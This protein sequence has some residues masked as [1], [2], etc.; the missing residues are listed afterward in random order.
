[1]IGLL[2]GLVAAYLVGS[3][4]SG[5]WVG[6]LTSGVDVRTM[7]SRRTGATNVQRSLG[8]G[9]GIV[10]LLIDFMKGLLPVL[11]MR[12]L[13][14]NQYAAAAVGLAAAIGHVWPVLAGFRGGRGVATGAGAIA[15]VAPPVVL[16]SLAILALIVATTRLV[17]L[18][19]ITAG[20]LSG[21][22]ATLLRGHFWVSDAAVPLA[23]AVGALIAWR[24]AD[25]IERL[26][27]GRESRLGK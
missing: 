3:L 7:G 1:M 25:N 9:P 20:L 8:T 5:L 14:G 12:G 15:G 23:V 17:S 6:Q 21:V 4:P 11:V 10:V 26:R 2:A 22:E 24:H 19:S 27:H 16:I 13:T 18:G